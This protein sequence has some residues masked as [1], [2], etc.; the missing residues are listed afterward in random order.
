MH[1]FFLFCEIENN[2]LFVQVHVFSTFSF[3]GR[4]VA[5]A[6]LHNKRTFLTTGARLLVGVGVVASFAWWSEESRLVGVVGWCVG[7][8]YKN[9]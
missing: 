4:V 8:V 6:K 7:V 5:L 3:F 9:N 1:V 2:F